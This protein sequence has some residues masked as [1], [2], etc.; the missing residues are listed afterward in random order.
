MPPESRKLLLDMQ[1]AANSIDEFV[2]GKTVAD[3]ANDKLLR[4]GIYFQFM[5]V[6]EALSQLRDLDEATTERLSEYWRIIGFRNQ[7]VHGYANVDD[8]IT[9]RIIES[10][11]PILRRE[12]QELLAE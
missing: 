9:W 8:E 5:I 12:L 11:L 4:A 1:A 3:L 10:K 7:I 6:G 2:A